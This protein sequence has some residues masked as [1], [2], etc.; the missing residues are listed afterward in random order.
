MNLILLGFWIGGD[1]FM[2]NWFIN[3]CR[4]VAVYIDVRDNALGRYFNVTS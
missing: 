3:N 4:L 2:A 1:P